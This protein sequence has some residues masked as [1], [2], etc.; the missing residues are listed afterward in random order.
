MNRADK[1]EAA[2]KEVIKEMYEHGLAWSELDKLKE[3]L[4]PDF[5]PTPEDY[6]ASKN[7]WR[8]AQEAMDLIVF[9]S[10]HLKDYGSAVTK[11]ADKIV[12]A[13]DG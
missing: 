8:L 13:K 6:Y 11:L 3:A 7:E 5:V 1:I 9:H 12:E 4:E 2:A 10:K